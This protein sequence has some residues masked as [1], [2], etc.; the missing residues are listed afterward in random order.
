MD[1]SFTTIGDEALE[2]RIVAW[3]LGEASAF[4]AAEIERLCDE[5]PELMIFK[6]RIESLHGLLAEAATTQEDE[7]WTLPPEKRRRIESLY[8]DGNTASSPPHEQRIRHGARRAKLAIA[9]CLFLAAVAGALVVSQGIARRE[10]AEQAA[11]RNPALQH[12]AAGEGVK[13]EASAAD[14]LREDALAALDEDAFGPGGSRGMVKSEGLAQHPAPAA[15]P[16]GL[17]ASDASSSPAVATAFASEEVPGDGA[18]AKSRLRAAGPA[19]PAEA[20]KAMVPDPP[21]DWQ[22]WAKWAEKLHPVTDPEGHGPDIGGDE[23]AMALSR[24]LGIIDADGHGPDPKSDEWRAAVEKKLIPE[25][26]RELLSSHDTTAVFRGIREHECLG[27]TSLCPD[28]CGHSGKLATFEIV[29]Y[30]HYAKPGQYGDPK[31]ESFQLLIEDNT[32]HRKVSDAIHAAILAL[33]QG[34]KVHLKWNHDYVTKDRS[35]FPERVIVTLEPVPAEKDAR[36]IPL[37][38]GYS[39]IAVDDARVLKAAEFAVREKKAVSP[40]LELAA[41]L[42]AQSQVVAGMNFKLLLKLADD[43]LEKKAEAVVYQKLDGGLSLSSW[44]WK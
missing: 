7:G 44:V 43:G 6:R 30:R 36:P 16:V 26:K 35:S 23:W 22:A 31:Q 13:N 33:K 20:A 28:R 12:Q 19:A 15:A 27:L 17:A 37:V 9:A 42:D 2:A 40:K 10:H 32:G 18:L 34:D 25:E 24:K 1:K 4:E 41:I 8:A 5:R 39:R 11:A 14:A 38:G 3:V 21:A 29:E